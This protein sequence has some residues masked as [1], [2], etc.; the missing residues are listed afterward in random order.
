MERRDLFK[1]P[2]VGAAIFIIMQWLTACS[3]LQNSSHDHNSVDVYIFS[4]QSNMEGLG[5]V[6][7]L[8]DDQKQLIKES[9]FW[10]DKSFVP[11]KNRL[12]NDTCRQ[13]ALGRPRAGDHRRPPA[14][15]AATG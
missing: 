9:W 8:P 14:P 5:R 7:E 10:N 6:S 4:G 15:R 1:I 2:S 3:S 11:A 13:G 12:Q